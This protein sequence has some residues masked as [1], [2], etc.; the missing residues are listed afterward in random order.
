MKVGVLGAGQLARMLALSAHPLGIELICM[1][2]TPAPCAASVTKTITADYQDQKAL[3]KFVQGLDVVTVENENI[4][5][6]TAQFIQ[7]HCC[8]YPSLQALQVSQDRLLEKNLFNELGIATPPYRAI[9]SLQDLKNAVAEISLPAVLKTRRFGYD[10][11]GQFLIKTAIQVE[12]AWKTIGGENLILEQFI[13]FDRE[14]SIISVRNVQGQILHYPLVENQHN[15]GI[16]RVSKAPYH[17]NLLQKKA[18]TYAEAILNKF[19]YVGVLAIEFFHQGEN[20]IANEMAPRVHNTG[21][22]TIEGAVT[23]QFENHLRAICN[24]PLGDTRNRG[25]S[26]MLNC[27]STLPKLI[28]ILAIKGAHFHTYEKQARKNRKLGHI[29]LNHEDL[30]ELEQSYHLIQQVVNSGI[31]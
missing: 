9:H 22:W 25:Y 28:D 1:D 14:V 2:P 15:Q 30:S 29:T 20:L 10:G 11:K 19:N 23:S 5:T 8:F 21:H 26:M 6:E 17:D 31:S 16:L 13:A 7:Q 24:F 4:P 27:I 18:K 3:S 12:E